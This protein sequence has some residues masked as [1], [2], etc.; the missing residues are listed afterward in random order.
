MP[1]VAA[2]LAP[3]WLKMW[4]PWEA[5]GG[6]WCLDHL[7]QSG[8]ALPFLPLLTLLLLLYSCCRMILFMVDYH[9]YCHSCVTISVILMYLYMFLCNNVKFSSHLSPFFPSLFSILSV[10]QAMQRAESPAASLLWGPKAETYGE[11]T[12]ERVRSGKTAINSSE[13]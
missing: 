3:S 2:P 13:E 10:A 1:M 4:L 12:G 5:L 11:R 6:P 9:H 8:A 7:R